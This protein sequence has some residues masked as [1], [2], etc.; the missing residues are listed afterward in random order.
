MET[1]MTSMIEGGKAQVSID[2][3]D[4]IKRPIP[5]MILPAGDTLVYFTSV[6][7]PSLG[8]RG[9]QY[10]Y[11]AVE[12]QFDKSTPL[13]QVAK[14]IDSIVREKMS[15][16]LSPIRSTKTDTL[17]INGKKVAITESSKQDPIAKYIS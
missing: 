17:I 2:P 16:F 5:G 1:V 15:D 10:V 11:Y 4:P 7:V 3:I 8:W 6:G 13:Q 14:Q 9:A 12:L